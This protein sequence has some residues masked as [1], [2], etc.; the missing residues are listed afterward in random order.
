MRK[1]ADAKMQK[2]KLLWTQMLPEAE[3]ALRTP[4]MKEPC[5]L[6]ISE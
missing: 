5:L 6:I 4:V 3:A 2:L 1:C